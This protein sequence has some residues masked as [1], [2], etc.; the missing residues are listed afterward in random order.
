[1][2]QMVDPV[3]LVQ[4]TEP[5]GPR[6]ERLSWSGRIGGIVL[7]LI[8]AAAVFAPWL[9]PDASVPNLD[10]VLQSPSVEHPFG[11][12]GLGQDVLGRVLLAGRIDLLVSLVG[13]ALSAAIGGVI[14]VLVGYSRGR[15]TAWLM[16]GLDAF[17]AFPLLV[18]ALLLLA[19]LGRSASTLI[20]AVAFINVPIFIR[21]V[22]SETAAVCELPF[23]DAAHC[24]GNSRMR[25]VVRH[26]LP[27]VV[28]SALT[29]VTT[30][31]GFAIML[32]GALGF[33]GVGI[34]PSQPEWGVMIQE[35]MQ[36]I[37]S[38]QWWLIFFP[39]AAI[40]VSVVSL[41]ALGESLLKS[42]RMR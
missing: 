42:R 34:D 16:R 10:A 17:Q 4:T 8:I 13:V 25:V 7:L 36:Y 19:F 15:W 41:Q 29:H 5:S 12:N 6:R 14:G 24:V 9:R 22:R 28:T 37:S 23:V 1:M 11:T 30:A 27:N 20:L 32:V 26:V 21:L 35:G 39:S 33:L 38:K 3:A 31:A 18:F 2:S 40:V